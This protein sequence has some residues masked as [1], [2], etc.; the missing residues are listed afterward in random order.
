M[1]FNLTFWDAKQASLRNAFWDANQL[2][3]LWLRLCKDKVMKPHPSRSRHLENN[4]SDELVR[5]A[6]LTADQLQNLLLEEQAYRNGVF[7][8]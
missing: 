7:G 4:L 6:D 2:Q 1:S 5:W 3:R 8:R